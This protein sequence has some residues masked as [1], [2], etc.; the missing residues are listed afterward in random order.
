L[1]KKTF[2]ETPLDRILNVSYKTTGFWSSIL[3]FGNVEVQVV[4]LIEPIIFQN[5]SRPG[6]LKDYIWKAH[7]RAAKSNP[8]RF[9]SESIS[10]IQQQIGYTKKDQR[11]V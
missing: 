4:G 1:F 8:H 10:H 5:V 11:I 6:P 7:E 2:V 3:G 9:D